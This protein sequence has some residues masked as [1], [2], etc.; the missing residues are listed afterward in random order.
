MDPF[1]SWRKLYDA[2]EQAWNNAIKEMTTMPSYVEA[3]GKML[4]VFLAYQKLV[5]DAMST[6]LTSFN[7]PTRDDVSRLGELLV[8]LEEKVDQLDDQV[9]ELDPG[10]QT[11]VLRAVEQKLEQLGAKAEKPHEALQGLSKQVGRVQ[12]IEQKVD[13]LDNRLEKLET[14]LAG[15][16]QQ[17]ARIERQTTPPANDAG[18]TGGEAAAERPK[19]ATGKGERAPA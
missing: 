2:T 14:A 7:L 17:L 15:L 16:G 18:G 13:K 6:Q 10:Q 12:L 9:G 3:Q 11:A 8:G 5:R 4:E 1:E 19:R